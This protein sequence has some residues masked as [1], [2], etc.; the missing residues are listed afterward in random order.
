[1]SSEISSRSFTLA[2]A[3]VAE[4]DKLGINVTD[5]LGR[6]A[7]LIPHIGEHIIILATVIIGLDVGEVGVERPR[8]VGIAD[9]AF[10]VVVGA[11]ASVAEDVVHAAD[12]RR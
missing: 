12:E 5:G 11:N 3:F 6:F 9:V 1:M 2:G 7:P 10:L 4:I 8:L